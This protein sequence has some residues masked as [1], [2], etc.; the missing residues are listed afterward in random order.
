MK[1]IHALIEL[2]IDGHLYEVLDT[3]TPY[4]L[5]RAWTARG[6]NYTAIVIPLE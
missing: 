4:Q 5:R 2:Y 3:Y 6:N 1:E